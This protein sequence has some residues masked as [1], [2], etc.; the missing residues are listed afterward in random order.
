MIRQDGI[1]EKSEVLALFEFLEAENAFWF[2]FSD[3]TP[4]LNSFGGRVSAMLWSKK[5]NLTDSLQ[6]FSYACK[7]R[8]ATKS[9]AYQ[10]NEKIHDKYNGSKISLD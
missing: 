5:N 7:F 3:R 2:R 8:V 4:E 9:L 10:K 6:M 1:R